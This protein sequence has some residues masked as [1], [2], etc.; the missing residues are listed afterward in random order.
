MAGTNVTFAGTSIQTTS[1]VVGELQHYGGLQKEVATIPIIRGDKSVRTNVQYPS[2]TITVKGRIIGTSLSTVKSQVDS[3]LLLME[4]V[5]NLDIDML[6][7]GSSVRR[8]LAEPQN[9]IVTEGAAIFARDIE[10]TF[11]CVD[12]WGRDTASTSIL[13]GTTISAS[14]TVTGSLTFGGTAL[15]QLPV[16]TLT[17]T[18]FT[19]AYLNTITITN[20]ATTQAMAIT[21]AWTAADVISI[22]LF[23]KTCT[24]NGT[25]VEFSGPWLYWSPGSGASITISDDFT[26]RSLSLSLSNLNLYK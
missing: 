18:S 10:I 22:D 1:V 13:S 20:P 24:V 2:R 6:Q 19:G 16:I 21:R 17:V 15:A 23:N 12:P 11:I 7:T 5:G 8:Y 9:V 25:A 26:A 14:P 4:G 3:L